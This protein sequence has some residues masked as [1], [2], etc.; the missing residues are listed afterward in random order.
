MAI[1][2][3]LS[4]PSQSDFPTLKY[5]IRNV[6]K[7]GGL[8]TG[9]AGLIAATHWGDSDSKSIAAGLALIASAL[10][11]GLTAISSRLS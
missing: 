11:F 2:E 1:T 7:I 10:A 4:D 3:Q 6:A 8:V 5:L 9:G